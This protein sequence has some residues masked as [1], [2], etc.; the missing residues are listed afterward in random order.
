MDR[1]KVYI[2]LIITA[3]DTED[4]EHQAKELIDE[5]VVVLLDQDRQPVEEYDVALVEPAEVI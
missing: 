3:E 5:G 2:E 4:A 1:F